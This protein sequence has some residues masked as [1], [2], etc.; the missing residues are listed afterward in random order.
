MQSCNA[1]EESVTPWPIPDV[2]KKL[3]SNFGYFV[4]FADGYWCTQQQEGELLKLTIATN[5]SL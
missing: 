4:R 3:N 5:M 2:A 1:N